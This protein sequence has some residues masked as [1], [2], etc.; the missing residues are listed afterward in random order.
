M[1]AAGCR[2]APRSVV[3]VGLFIWGW[4][5]Q[6]TGKALPAAPRLFTML[7]IPLF[8]FCFP[9]G[10]LDYWRLFLRAGSL[11]PNGYSGPIPCPGCVAGPVADSL[12][13]SVIPPQGVAASAEQLRIPSVL[14]SKL[15]I[16]DKGKLARTSAAR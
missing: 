5:Q 16:K 2:D 11:G 15:G 3:S 10:L 9:R 4:S 8:C 12:V 6:A 7:L 14:Q 13:G 1:G